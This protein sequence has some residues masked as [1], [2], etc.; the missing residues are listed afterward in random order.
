MDGPATNKRKLGFPEV[1]K[2]STED[3]TAGTAAQ[4]GRMESGHTAGRQKKSLFLQQLEARRSKAKL[5]S[6]KKQDAS[7]MLDSKSFFNINS[8]PFCSY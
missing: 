7:G 1:P 2:L 8:G 4:Q 3:L 5:A 6:P